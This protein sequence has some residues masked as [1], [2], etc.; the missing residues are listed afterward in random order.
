MY[1]RFTYI[2]ISRQAD[3]VIEQCYVAS[4]IVFRLNA[5]SRMLPT[6]IISHKKNSFPI[7]LMPALHW[8]TD[9]EMP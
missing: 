2:N 7:N 4:S 8:E 1:T 3:L 6:E 5:L 9:K